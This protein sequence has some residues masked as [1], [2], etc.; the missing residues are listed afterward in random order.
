MIHQSI[1]KRLILL[2]SFSISSIYTS[3]S[4]TKNWSLGV[5]TAITA[6]DFTTSKGNTIDYLKNGAGN[7]YAIGYEQALLDTNKFVGQSTPKAIYFLQHKRVSKLLTKLTLGLHV[8]FNQYNAVGSV[9]NLSFDYQ[10]NYAGL[11]LSLG[12]RLDLGKKWHILA[13]GLLAGQHILQGNQQVNYTYIDLTKD[14]SFKGLKT[15]L[16]YELS[17]EKQLNNSLLFFLS[18]GNS[19]T[20]KPQETG[21]ANLNFHSTS[22]IIGIKIKGI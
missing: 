6:Y 7:S 15:F 12:P 9:Q 3:V 1:L 18:G 10:T 21:V 2:I 14:A 5:G 17:I 4:Q 20:F 22:L 19:R 8:L 11:Q 16:G 13:K